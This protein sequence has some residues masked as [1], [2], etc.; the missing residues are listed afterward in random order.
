MIY[1]TD[2]MNRYPT[3]QTNFCSPVNP[4]ISPSAPKIPSLA[5]PT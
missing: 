3:P 2:L 1:S 4:K 5:P